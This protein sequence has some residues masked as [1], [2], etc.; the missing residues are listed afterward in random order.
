MAVFHDGSMSG[1]TGGGT[2]IQGAYKSGH[3]FVSRT[4]KPRHEEKA[5]VLFRDW[6]VEP[7]DQIT[8]AMVSGP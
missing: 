6:Q 3:E 4:F 7:L 8:P 2:N 5:N 1:P